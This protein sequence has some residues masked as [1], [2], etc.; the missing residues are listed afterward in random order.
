[1]WSYCEVFLT[2]SL[3]SLSTFLSWSVLYR[4]STQAPSQELSRLLSSQLRLP[5]PPVPLPRFSLPPRRVLPG[6]RFSPRFLSHSASLL[7]SPCSFSFVSLANCLMH[8]CLS[9]L[10]PRAWPSSAQAP[11]P[12]S[13]ALGQSRYPHL[14]CPAPRPP[15][16]FKSFRSPPRPRSPLSPATPRPGRSSQPAGCDAR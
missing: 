1:M 13:V 8:F 11:L 4:C 7:C 6:P 2:E 14:Q 3:D 5:G 12:P 10:H 9:L 16:R 15:P